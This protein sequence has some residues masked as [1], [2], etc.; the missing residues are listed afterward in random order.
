[1]SDFE[2]KEDFVEDSFNDF[3]FEEQQDTFDNSLNDLD[4][5]KAKEQYINDDGSVAELSVWEKIKSIA[6][7]NNI[8]VNDPKSSCKHCYGK[9]YIGERILAR[10]EDGNAIDKEPVPCSCIFPKETRDEN[11]GVV[12][13]RKMK[14]KMEKHNKKKKK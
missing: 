5:F 7:N 13:N 6:E 4:E 11:M 14:R 12:P 1:M 2:K 3:G 10:D 8:P 9:G